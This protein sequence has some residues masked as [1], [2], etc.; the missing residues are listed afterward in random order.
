MGFFEIIGFVILIGLLVLIFG[1]QKVGRQVG[2][3]MGTQALMLDPARTHLVP[4]GNYVISMTEVDVSC[5]R[6]DGLV[7]SVQWQD[8]EKVEVLTT[9]DGPL[10]PDVFWLLHGREGNGGCVIPQGA[11]GDV[12]LL[13]RLQKLPGFDNQVFINA[14]GSTQPAVFV[15]WKR[16]DPSSSI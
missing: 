3:L 4:E 1:S 14:M 7:E 12:E 11:R 16:V 9:S 2:S 13:E 15:C 8:L 6:P 5:H 10:L